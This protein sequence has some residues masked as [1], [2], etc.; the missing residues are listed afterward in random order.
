VH[1]DYE[2]DTLVVDT[3]GISIKSFV[4]SFRTPHTDKLHVIERYRVIEGGLTL[5]ARIRVEDPDTFVQPWETMVPYR[6]AQEPFGENICQEGNFVP[7]S[8]E[9]GVPKADKPDF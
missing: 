4:D 3:I 9:Y 8:E 7:F 6:L 5:E 1:T 2:G